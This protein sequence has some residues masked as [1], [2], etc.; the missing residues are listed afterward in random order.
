MLEQLVK[1]LQKATGCSEARGWGAGLQA[2]NT[3]RAVV[4]V[5]AEME[6]VRVGMLLAS[7]GLIVDDV[8]A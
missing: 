1:Q 6:C 2:D 8:Q 5:G 3:G 7:I 4:K